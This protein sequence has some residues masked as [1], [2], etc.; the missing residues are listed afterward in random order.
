MTDDYKLTWRKTPNGRWEA[1]DIRE[2]AG[3]W[4]CYIAYRDN[5]AR[6]GSQWALTVAV[7]GREG[8]Q[9]RTGFDLLSTAKA[10]ALKTRCHLCGRYLPFATMEPSG[11]MSGWRCRDHEDC[12]R[13][14]AARDAAAARI[15]REIRDTDMDEIGVTDTADG[16]EL[17]FTSNRNRTVI[18]CTETDLDRLFRVLARRKRDRAMADIRV[19]I[20]EC[21]AALAAHEERETGS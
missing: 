20:S 15:T 1:Q 16:P 18:R 7:P 5:Q 21:D 4:P 9:T 14:S 2:P 6:T 11:G 12:A 3:K 19:M 13:A 17:I 8:T 10:A